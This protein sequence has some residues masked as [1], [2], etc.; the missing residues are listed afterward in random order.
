MP[1]NQSVQTL[2]LILRSPAERSEAWRFEG[3]QLARRTCRTARPSA[4]W[5]ILCLRVSSI[6]QP[7]A[8]PSRCEPGP[9]FWHPRRCDT[10]GPSDESSKSAGFR[11]GPTSRKNRDVEDLFAQAQVYHGLGLFSEAQAA[12]GQVLKKR[13][14]H[15]D[16]LQLL[17]LSEHQ[18]GNSEA[19]AHA[20]RRALQ[21]DPR[22]AEAHSNLGTVLLALRRPDEALKCCDDAIALQPDFANA[23]Y[24]RGNALSRLQRFADAI[25]SYDRSIALRPGHMAFV[26]RGGAFKEL[27]QS[28]EAIADFDRALAL[29]PDHAVAWT[30]RGGSLLVLG[31]CDEALASYDKA[32]S[33]NP[34]LPEAWLGRANVL[35]LT[36]RVADAMATCR[37][38]LAIEPDSV[39]ALTQL[40]QCHALQGEPETA[41]SCLDRALA[42]KPDDE[43]ALSNRIFTLDF[44]GNAG[45]AQ[46]QAARSEWWRQI[47][48]KISAEHLPQLENDRDAT[49]RIVLGYVSAEFR[50]RSAALS[51][52]P[53]LQ[54]HDKT[55]FEVICY[56]GIP[57]EDAVT[58]SFRKGADRWRDV[59]QWSDDRLADCIQADKVDILID[60]SGHTD[61]NRLRTFARKPAPIQVTAWGHASGTGVPTIDY[62]FSDPVLVPTAVRHLF[63]EKVYDLPCAMIIEPPPSELRTLEPPVTFNGHLTYGVFSRANRISNSAIGV[64]ARILRS[65]PTS[66]LLIKYRLIDDVSIQNMLLEKFAAHGVGLDRIALMGSSSHQEHLA[67]YRRVDICLDPFPHVGGVSTWE[68]L[69]MGVPVVTKLGNALAKRV[70]GAIL[71][72]VGLGDWISTDDDEYVDIALRSTPDRLKALRCALPALIDERCGPASYARAVEEAYRVMWK[73]RCGELQSQR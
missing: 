54:N 35:M 20:L 12:Y 68:A 49:R 44:S 55:H 15:F 17:G 22:S 39:L 66:K 1:R 8:E 4:T 69:H 67:A 65:D 32:L 38:A 21:V 18:G 9:I 27:R 13:P 60:L 26:N 14:K 16:A 5:L 48:S 71:S 64:W 63:A 3:C 57:T 6:L 61:G 51:F 58:E 23:H 56:S 11:R 2:G 25:A 73:K 40:G 28:D 30:S 47:G 36:K 19:A 7:A 59:S 52:W 29:A 70:G 62:L 53:V 37:R 24:I 33:I 41:I 34:E 43:D 46:H 50:Q 42:I 72:A 10:K 45:F 31:R